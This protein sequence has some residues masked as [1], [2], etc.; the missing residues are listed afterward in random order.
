MYRRMIFNILA[1]NQDDHTKNHSFLMF[2]NGNWDLSPA[3]DI[4]F[5]YQKDSKFIAL[6]Q[7][8]WIG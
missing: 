4:C 3:Y 7:M 2:Q 1:R 5:S 8:N 6:Q